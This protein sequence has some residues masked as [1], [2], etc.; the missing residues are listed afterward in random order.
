VFRI[1][2]TPLF[3]PGVRQ[4]EDLSRNSSTNSKRSSSSRKGSG[5]FW[6]PA[7]SYYVLAGSV[8]GIV[9]FVIW[10]IFLEGGEE[11]P[12]VTAGIAA[13]VLMA[14]AVVV[15]EVVLR[16]ARHRFLQNRRQLDRNFR[17]G[18]KTSGY[19][20]VKKMSLEDHDRMLGRIYKKSEAARVLGDL[21]EGHREVFAICEEYLSITESQLRSTDV[22]SPRYVAF[23]NGRRRVK[24][25]HRFHL[26]AWTEIES[27]ELLRLATSLDEPA[28]RLDAADRAETVIS[29]AIMQYPNE[30]TLIESARALREFRAAVRYWEKVSEAE[31][32]ESAGKIDEALVI[33]KSILAGL[34]DEE[35]AEEE[36]KQLEDRLERKIRDLE[37]RSGE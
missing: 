13:S 18:L 34:D 9:F 4:E 35:F 30:E 15:R 29:S 6:L 25:L 28:A 5:P 31:Q 10:G 8:S 23:R 21:A 33:Y 20:R 14:V 37:T 22:S 27:K 32:E 2:S 19:S 12:W 3:D 36:R 26:M 11:A 1:A 24:K 7:I 17:R 16:N